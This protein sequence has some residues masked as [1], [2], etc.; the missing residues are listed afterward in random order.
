MLTNNS[1][2]NVE[3]FDDNVIVDKEYNVNI[4]HYERVL[5]CP[6]AFK[7]RIK[8]VELSANIRTSNVL[9]RINFF[10]DAHGILLNGLHKSYVFKTLHVMPI[11]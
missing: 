8:C 5:K 9:I 4:S 1:N 6:L 3:K 2:S 10:L 11:E 7:Y